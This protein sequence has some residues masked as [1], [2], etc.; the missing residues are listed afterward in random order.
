MRIQ[1]LYEF[2]V[3]A[4]RL[5]FTETAKNF[6]ISQ[7]VLSDHISGL[8]KELGVRLLVRD[9]HSVRL[10]EAGRIFEKGAQEIILDY[11][12]ALEEL[13]LYQEGVSTIIRI[14]FLMGSYGA[15]LPLVCERYRKTHPEIEFR[16]KTLELPEMQPALNKNEIDVGFMIFTK[17]FEGSQYDHHVL[18]TDCYKLAVPKGHHL[19]KRES[20]NLADLAGEHVISPRFNQSKSMQAQM[21]IK[22]QNAGVNVSVIDD[23]S[24]VGALMATCVSANAVALALDHLDVFG[25][26]NVVFLPIDDL[27][28]KILVGPVWKKS[29]ETEALLSFLSFF[30]RETCG[31]SKE[32]FLSR[33]GP[34]SFTW[35]SDAEG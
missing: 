6:F 7:S 12:Q 18:Y 28:T 19:A 21:S 4:T 22:M 23:V 9:R 30:M 5:N 25:G 20:V 13:S 35:R 26:G 1:T 29:K 24:D 11:E 2:L 3:L 32:D 27:D 14:G 34:E 15:F 17:G 10:T 31:F 8:E 16:F 33:K